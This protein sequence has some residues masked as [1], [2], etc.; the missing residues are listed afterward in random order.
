MQNTYDYLGLDKY[1]NAAYSGFAI[2]SSCLLFAPTA[3]MVRWVSIWRPVLRFTH[4]AAMKAM[5]KLAGVLGDTTGLAAGCTASAALCS[6]TMNQTL[7][8]GTRQEPTAAAPTAMLPTA[9]C[10]KIPA[11]PLL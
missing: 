6:K 10:M 8:T 7:W 11:R 1:P 3:L 2:S 9:S 5:V 4:M